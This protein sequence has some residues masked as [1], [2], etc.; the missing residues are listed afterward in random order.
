MTTSR[1][2]DKQTAGATK[3]VESSVKVTYERNW[4]RTNKNS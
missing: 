4:S 3:I 1:I 2:N